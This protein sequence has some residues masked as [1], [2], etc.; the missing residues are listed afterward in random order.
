MAR[1]DVLS[2]LSRIAR[3]GR[4]ADQQGLRSADALALAAELEEKSERRRMSRRELLGGLLGTAAVAATGA[5]SRPFGAFAAPKKGGGAPRIAIIGGGMAGL[6]C[7]DNLRAAGLSATIYEANTRLGGR[8]SSTHLFPGQVAEKGGELIDN[9][10]KTMLGYA[11]EFDLAVEDVGKAPGHELF[12]VGGQL[13]SEAEVMD[14]WRVLVG[15]A[16]PDLKKLGAP[17]FYAHNDH[18][19]ELDYTDLASWLQKV[20]S[21]LPVVRTVIDIAYNIEYGLETHEQSCLNL[22]TFIHFDRRSKFTPFGVFSDERYHI[23]GG[24]DLIAKRIAERLP[25]PIVYGAWLKKLA[26]T[27]TGEYHLWF[28]GDLVPTVA[29]AVVLTVPFSVLQ[30]TGTNSVELDDSLG[31]SADKKRAIAELRYGANAKTMIGFEGRPWWDLHGCNGVVYSDL[32]NMQ[33]TWETSWTTAG[34]TSVLTDYSGGDRAKA[35]QLQQN[36]DGTFGGAIGCGS[37]HNGPGG[38]LDIQGTTLPNQAEAFLDDLDL[39]L[40]GVKSRATRI[41]GELL[42]ERGHWLV[43][44]Y[45][46]GSYTCPQPGYFTTIAGLEGEPA[47]NL[48]FAG[49][50]ADSFYSWQG[51]MEGAA[52]SG[53]AAA[54]SILAGVKKGTL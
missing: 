24:N 6:A 42:V 35:L 52:L 17:T 26:R 28:Q 48:K 37:C 11:N 51:F 5:V 1:T 49:E 54:T 27:A 20:A 46:K 50:H 44:K 9:L 47:G 31:L 38:F 33:N 18:E 2:R 43:Q 7:A 22:L 16:R 53:L 3:I 29:D 15:R 10:H 12:W 21:D 45:S 32:P 19:V 41:G 39:T 25:G 13:Y 34:A 40:P 23:V 36:P 4:F 8:V 30:A 14:E